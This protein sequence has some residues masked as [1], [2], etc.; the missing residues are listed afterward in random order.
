M[1]RRVTFTEA[2]VRRVVGAAGATATGK[3]GL[4]MD[5]GCPG[6]GLR[7]RAGGA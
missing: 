3:D 6:L 4:I 1:R 7:M 5:A 2:S